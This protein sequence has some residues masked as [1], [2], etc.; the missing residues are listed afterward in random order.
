[1]SRD[2][3]FDPMLDRDGDGSDI[4]LPGFLLDPVGVVRR[5]WPWMLAAI[6]GAALTLGARRQPMRT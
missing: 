1:M 4:A 6:P 3:G 5:R 2:E